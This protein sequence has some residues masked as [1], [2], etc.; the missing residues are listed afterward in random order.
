M[1]EFEEVEDAAT[2]L[3]TSAALLRCVSD[4]P[5]L[6]LDDVSST[7]A[8]PAGEGLLDAMPLD[9]DVNRALAANLR[10]SPPGCDAAERAGA[11]AA[12]A[13]ALHALRTDGDGDCLLHAC[14]LSLWGAHDRAHT[15]RQRIALALTEPDV[16]AEFERLWLCLLYTSPSPRDKRQSRMPSSA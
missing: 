13:C 11:A 3:A 7:L 10:W 5:F 9:A 6:S 14:A 1:L 8:L 12:L 15:L 2:D 16:A 4:E